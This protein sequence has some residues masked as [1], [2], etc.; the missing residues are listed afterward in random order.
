[1]KFER[2]RVKTIL[3]IDEVYVGD[4]GYFSDCLLE[5]KEIVES[6][7]KK[8]YGKIVDID[9]D[10][11]SDD[12]FKSDINSIYRFYFYLVHEV[13]GSA[14]GKFKH[15]FLTTQVGTGDNDI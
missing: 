9:R 1:M 15:P 13:E 7:N 4:V 10:S 8:F 14:V 11:K 2:S 6:E 5:L 3:D 12:C